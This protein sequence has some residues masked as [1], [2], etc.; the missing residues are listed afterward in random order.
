M[1]DWSKAEYTLEY[2]IFWNRQV[3]SSDG[4][5]DTCIAF[6]FEYSLRWTRAYSKKVSHSY[7]LAL[8]SRVRSYPKADFHSRNRKELN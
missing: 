2:R 5:I 4:D 3:N 1:F 7:V 8:G 6:V